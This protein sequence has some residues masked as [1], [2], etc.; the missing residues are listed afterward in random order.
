MLLSSGLNILFHLLACL[1]FTSTIYCAVNSCMF[2]KAYKPQYLVGPVRRFKWMKRPWCKM[3]NGSW[4]SASNSRSSRR[5][6]WRVG[7]TG[8]PLPHLQRG[9][10]LLISCSL[11]PCRMQVLNYFN[12]EVNRETRSVEF[13]MWNFSIK[14]NVANKIHMYTSW[15][16]AN[17][18]L[19]SRCY[20]V[21]H[22]FA[23]KI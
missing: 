21:G 19:L 17:I 16:P 10:P 6:W 11:L 3:M 4:H 7:H 23:Y 20:S 13:L 5:A 12:L 15:E 8:K 2:C 14:K 22:H 1:D 18:C 9:Q